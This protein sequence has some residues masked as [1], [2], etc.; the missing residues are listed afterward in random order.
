[1]R[2][3]HYVYAVYVLSLALFQSTVDMGVQMRT[4]FC[5][6]NN[7]YYLKFICFRVYNAQFIPFG[8]ASKFS[9]SFHLLHPLLGLGVWLCFFLFAQNF[10]QTQNYF[11][12][13]ST[14]QILILIND[15]LHLFIV[16]VCQFNSCCQSVVVWI[17]ILQMFQFQSNRQPTTKFKASRKFHNIIKLFPFICRHQNCRWKIFPF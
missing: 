7:I 12:F 6:I 10:R 8:L 2:V 16:L 14:E 13:I 9:H 5:K 1:M 4:N 17:F 11:P 15:D 3:S